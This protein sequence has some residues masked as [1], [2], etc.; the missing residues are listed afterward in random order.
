M[1][2]ALRQK[3]LEE[4]EKIDWKELQAMVVAPIRLCL[5]NNMMYFVMDEESLVTIW[6]KLKSQY[7]YKSLTNKLYFK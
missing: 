7:M 5:T 1:V 2:K 6:Q 3:K 4:M